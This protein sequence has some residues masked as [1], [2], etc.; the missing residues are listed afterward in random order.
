A[1]AAARR[2]A[3]EQLDRECAAAAGAFPKARL[4]LVGTVEDWLGEMPAL[5]AEE[6]LRAALADGRAA[7]AAAGGAG[8]GPHRSDLAVTHAEKGIAAEAASTG[9]Q[10]AVLIAIVLG[11]ARLQRSVRGE[12]PLLLLDEVAAHLDGARRTALFDTLAGLDGQ[13]WITGTDPALFAPLSGAARFLSIAD[14]T[15]SATIS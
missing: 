8:V 12:P 10:K 3:I 11:Q 15:L 14:G 13:A 2:D 9:E 4:A 5:A 7:D 1:V 6:R